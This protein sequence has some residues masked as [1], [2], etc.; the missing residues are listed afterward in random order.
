MVPDLDRLPPVDREVITRALSA[1]P[2]ARWPS[3]TEMMLALE[4]TSLEKLHELEQQEDR[5]TQ[6]IES[7]KGE[8]PSGPIVGVTAGNLNQIIYEIV[9]K[10]GADTIVTETQ[11]AP[12]FHEDFI[13]HVFQAAIP[14]GAART[15]LATFAQP[16]FGQ[17]LQDNDEGITFRISLPSTFWRQL[18]SKPVGLEVRIRL[19]RANPLSA[20][21]IKVTSSVEPLRKNHPPSRQLLDELGPEI[22]DSLQKTLQ[23]DAVKRT[24]DR[25]LWPH[26]LKVIPIH[27]NGS[28]DEAIECRGKD[29][30]R[31]G[32]GFY[33]PHDLSTS[34]VLIELPNDIQPPS[35]AIPATLVRAKR[36]P[37]GWYE[38]GAL[39][40]VPNLRQLPEI[41]LP[42][43][44]V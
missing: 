36:C 20:T 38:V 18:L 31:S 32:I 40:R 3:C 41:N 9:N 2:Q 10:A 1:D 16:W 19:A 6:L 13:E 21:P 23:S 42:A 5:F 27:A 33:L 43:V 37:D 8:P 25:L 29:I 44:H 15:K 26:P 28:Q 12:I 35:I 4:G 7:T 22:I 24:Q 39:F 17:V 34:D 14:L 30:S 11:I